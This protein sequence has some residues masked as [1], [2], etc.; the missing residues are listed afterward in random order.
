M[1]LNAQYQT[2]IWKKN[3]KNKKSH[4]RCLLWPTIGYITSLLVRK[5]TFLPIPGTVAETT[6]SGKTDNHMPVQGLQESKNVI[7]NCNYLNLLL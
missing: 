3:P 4:V 6:C 5:T 7:R 2:N 1:L